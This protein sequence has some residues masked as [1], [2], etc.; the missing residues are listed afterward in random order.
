MV[1]ALDAVSAP[2]TVNNFVFLA[3]YHYFQGIASHRIIPGF[4]L[5]GGDPEGTG[6]GGPGYRF[7]DELPQPG[8]YELGSLAMANAGRDATGASSS[9]SRDTTGCAC[10]RST[11]CSVNWSPGGTSWRR[12]TRWAP[13]ADAPKEKVLIESVDNRSK[14]T[15]RPSCTFLRQ[16]LAERQHELEAGLDSVEVDDHVPLAG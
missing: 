16:P 8:R 15:P 9:S 11:R 12:S 5:Q 7:E 14:A 2:R 4:V 13:V 10:R 3:R 1:F 6:A